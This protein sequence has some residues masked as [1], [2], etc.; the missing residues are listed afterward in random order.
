[1]ASG[2]S[3]TNPA[4]AQ[5][6]IALLRQAGMARRVELA[7]EMTSFAIDAAYTAVRR[8]Y[9]AAN[10]L[11]INLLFVEQQY[12]LALANRLRA[13]LTEP[14]REQSIGKQGEVSCR[15]ERP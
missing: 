8:R 13:T 10:A 14:A 3:D 7:A 4:A 6:Q 1:M 11:E 9:P 12:G 15:E 2:I 5:V